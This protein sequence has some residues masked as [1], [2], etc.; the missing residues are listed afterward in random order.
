MRSD[1][2]Q[3]YLQ[4]IARYPLLEPSQEIELSRRVRRM[5]DLQSSGNELSSEERREVKSGKRAEDQMIK[6]N[7]RLVVSVAKKY[8]RMCDF[9]TI[10]DLIQEGSEHLVKAVHRFNAERGYKFSTYAYFWLRQAMGRAIANQERTIRLPLHQ[11]ERLSKAKRFVADHLSEHGVPPSAKC[12]AKHLGVSVDDVLMLGALSAK[13]MSLDVSV[14]DDGSPLIELIAAPE[15]DEPNASEEWSQMIDLLQ[16]LE[17]RQREM[18]E[19]RYGINNGK[20]VTLRELA[21]QHGVTQER[22]RQVIKKAA[23]RLQVLANNTALRV[24]PSDPDECYRPLLERL[25]AD[26]ATFGQISLQLAAAGRFTVYG[27]PVGTDQI[28]RMFGRLRIE[29]RVLQ[30][31]A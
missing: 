16:W 19:M 8:A 21:R 10:D 30:E 31:A 26:G 23:D 13:H 5:L 3:N 12:V 18:L 20:P 15:R 1:S 11:E 17:P 7:L 27:N 22:V 29:R 6:C 4:Q 24:V 25:A 14:V 28:K 2:M 9:L